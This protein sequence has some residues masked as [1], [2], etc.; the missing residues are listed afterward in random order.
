VGPRASL[1][2][3]Y[4]IKNVAHTRNR[5]TVPRSCSPLSSYFID[6]V[7]PVHYCVIFTWMLRESFFF[8]DEFTVNVRASEG[9]LR[10]LNVFIFQTNF[11]IK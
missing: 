5:T 4:K 8:I 1:G 11:G 2:V 9:R 7:V 6:C 10:G 3:L